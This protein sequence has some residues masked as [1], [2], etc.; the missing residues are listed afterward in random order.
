[1]LV[2]FALV[3]TGP[4]LLSLT[5][6]CPATTVENEINT[7]LQEDT[8][9]N[10]RSI[11]SHG[12]M[13]VPHGIVLP[14]HPCGAHE[15][16]W[17]RGS[18]HCRYRGQY[19]PRNQRADRHRKAVCALIRPLEVGPYAQYVAV[20]AI[21][22][23]RTRYMALLPINSKYEPLI[24]LALGTAASIITIL[25]PGA[26]TVARINGQSGRRVGLGNPP[27]NAGQ[28]KAQWNTICKA[29]PALAGAELR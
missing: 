3:A 19:G 22:P 11:R 4:A 17:Q 12:P 7:V 18:I 6:K 24:L 14:E 23:V 8:E 16:I 25:N 2:R 26:A 20:E 10:H 1:M 15:H 21:Q 9:S 28:F 27:K 5:R 29:N 13:H